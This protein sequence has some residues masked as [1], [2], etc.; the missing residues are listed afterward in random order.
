MDSRLA[1]TGQLLPRASSSLPSVGVRSP[2]SWLA[3]WSVIDWI[4][5]IAL[6]ALGHWANTWRPFE[7]RLGPQLHDPNIAYPFTTGSEQVVPA[8]LLWRLSTVVPALLLLPLVL[9]PPRH[10]SR[11]RLLSELWL[12]LT[13]SV[14]MGFLFICIVKSMV[15]RLRPDFIARCQPNADGICTGDAAVVTEGRKSFPSGHSQLA[16]SGLGYVSLALAAALADVDAPRFGSLWKLIVAF[17]PAL[18]ALLIALSR[19]SDYWHHWE[20]VLVGTLIGCT[21][22]CIAFRL[23]FPSP[24]YAPAGERLVP[25]VIANEPADKEHRSPPAVAAV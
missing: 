15:G 7:R 6:L 14:A 18:L 22:A 16:F 4:V 23:R 2:S 12:G 19:I 9:R 25:H 8:R 11:M 17:S 21:S 5:A 3:R 1:E 20:D 10:V 24:V 13:S